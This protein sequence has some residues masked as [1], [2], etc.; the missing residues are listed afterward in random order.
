[1]GDEQDGEKRMPNTWMLTQQAL[2]QLLRLTPREA[3]VLCWVTQGKRNDEIGLILGT[4]PLT[5][6][7]HL[8]HIHEKLGVQTHM[9]VAVL[10]VLPLPW[11]WSRQQPR[12]GTVP[13]IMDGSPGGF[14]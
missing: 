6:Q 4:S 13:Q 10:R 11:H 7:K 3:E 2:C 12:D 14:A 8:E 1:M 5:V 9:A